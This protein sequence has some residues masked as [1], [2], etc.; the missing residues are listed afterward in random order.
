MQFI[1]LEFPIKYFYIIPSK[2]PSPSF[3]SYFRRIYDAEISAA[4]IPGDPS[5]AA[6]GRQ[7]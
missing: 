4:A 5:S 3:K 6:P 1:A 7:I 2:D